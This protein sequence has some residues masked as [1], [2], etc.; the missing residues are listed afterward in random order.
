MMNEEIIILKDNSFKVRALLI[1]FSFLII[2]T[3]IHPEGYIIGSILFIVFFFGAKGLISKRY[4]S[5]V[6]FLKQ[7]N[8]EKA[9]EIF[10]GIYELMSKSKRFGKYALLDLFYSNRKT[11]KES[12]LAYVA[13]CYYNENNMDKAKEIYAQLLKEFPNGKF[14]KLKSE[15]SK[16]E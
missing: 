3:L 4:L 11:I 1:L 7:G 6:E 16:S 2:G 13:L 15:L 8:T 14:H 9:R 12:S 5:G 10:L